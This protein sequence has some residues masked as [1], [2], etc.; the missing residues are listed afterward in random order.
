M[1]R[2]CACE[3]ILT[4]PDGKPLIPW[5]AGEPSLKVCRPFT[6]EVQSDLAYQARK[7]A[8]DNS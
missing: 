3:G 5:L 4:N 1:K 7:S 2:I 6:C 8:Q